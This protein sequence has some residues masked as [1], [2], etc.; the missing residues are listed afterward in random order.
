MGHRWM[1]DVLADL[2]TF[3]DRNGL[4]V[5][6]QKLAETASIAAAEIGIDEVNVA[7]ALS[8]VRGREGT[9]G[10]DGIRSFELLG[11]G[12]FREGA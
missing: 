4:P 6:A 10:K 8:P 1:I 7:A 12:R 2:E 5:L 9:D 3:A 11:G